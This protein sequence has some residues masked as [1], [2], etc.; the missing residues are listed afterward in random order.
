MAPVSRIRLLVQ[1]EES[2]K[3]EWVL[4]SRES[5]LVPAPGR[6]RGHATCHQPVPGLGSSS[7]RPLVLGTAGDLKAHWILHQLSNPES[8]TVLV[9]QGSQLSRKGRPRGRHARPEGGTVAPQRCRRWH[10]GSSETHR[11]GHATVRFRV[12]LVCHGQVQPHLKLPEDPGEDKMGRGLCQVELHTPVCPVAGH[13]A[14]RGPEVGVHWGRWVQETPGS[15]RPGCCAARPGGTAPRGPEWAPAPCQGPCCCPTSPLLSGNKAEEPAPR[16][17]VGQTPGPQTGT[18]FRFLYLS[19][20]SLI[21]MCCLKGPDIKKK[22][23]KTKTQN[24]NKR[25][26]PQKTPLFPTFLK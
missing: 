3:V 16:L 11:A 15:S 14:G 22:Q 20:F 13:A 4:L 1:R 17:L 8:R 25:T 6:Q 18:S 24:E 19:T 10:P 7:V 2:C 5:L 23:N 12:P 26:P 21:Q 9:S